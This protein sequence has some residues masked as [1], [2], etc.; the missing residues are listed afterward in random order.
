MSIFQ[1]LLFLEHCN[2][3][4]FFKA[5]QLDRRLCHFTGRGLKKEGHAFLPDLYIFKIVLSVYF[6][7]LVSEVLTMV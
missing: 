4:F 5:M 3:F 2:F 6:N 7:C 1:F